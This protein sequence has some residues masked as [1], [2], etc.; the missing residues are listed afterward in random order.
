VI[1]REIDDFINELMI[2]SQINHRNIV[3]LHGCCLEIEVPL[4][5]YEFIS[6]GTLYHHLHVEDLVSLSWKDRVRIAVETARALAYLH[7]LT[8]VSIIHRDVKSP[9]IL[10]DDNLIVKLSD[11]GASRGMF[12]LIKLGWRQL[13]KVHLVTWTLRSW[14]QLCKVHLVTWT[15]RTITRGILLRRA[16]SIVLV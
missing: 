10:L 1:Q 9:N 3:K 11:F 12:W 16:M 5:V 4:L 14:R 15:L 6:N 2:L 8:S 13:C 7:S